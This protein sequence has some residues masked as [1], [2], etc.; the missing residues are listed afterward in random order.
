MHDR[1]G[2]SGVPLGNHWE[3][4]GDLRSTA[5]AIAGSN[6]STVGTRHRIDE[7]QAQSVAVRLF[8][9][10]PVLEQVKANLRI[11]SRSIVFQDERS[12]TVL[13]P[14]PYG[15]RASG[16]QVLQFIVE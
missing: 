12:S 4:Y 9:L 6:G 8:S 15:H 5:F 13:D 3:R 2:R 14:Q 10:D 16:R 11:E 1:R 7:G